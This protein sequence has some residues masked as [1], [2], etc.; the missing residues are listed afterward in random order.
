MSEALARTLASRGLGWAR[1]DPD[2]LADELLEKFPGQQ[3]HVDALV[4]T[5]ASDVL[6]ALI[7]APGSD[8]GAKLLQAHAD[9][10]VSEWGLDPGVAMWAVNAWLHAISGIAV[11][12]KEEGIGSL[13]GTT[14]PSDGDHGGTRV[15]GAVSRLRRLR[16][17]GTLTTRLA[18]TVA[19][20]ELGTSSITRGGR[21]PVPIPPQGEAGSLALSA[22]NPAE[23]TFSPPE[24]FSQGPDVPGV[25]D[26]TSP[27][28]PQTT[29]SAPV[30]P[31]ALA[32]GSTEAMPVLVRSDSALDVRAPEWL[33]RILTALS[34]ALAVAAKHRLTLLG[35]LATLAVVAIV[36]AT[37]PP[38]PE[39]A[40]RGLT[41]SPARSASGGSGVPTP[42]AGGVSSTAT[43]SGETSAALASPSP[44]EM[45]TVSVDELVAASWDRD[46]VE[47]IRV[48]QEYLG[49]RGG[50][51]AYASGKLYDAL[52]QYGIVLVGLQQPADAID[53]W[54]QAEALDAGRPEAPRRISTLSARLAGQ[55]A[56]EA[57]T[58]EVAVTATAISSPTPRVSVTASL[59]RGLGTPSTV[60]A[61]ET[62][63]EALEAV[64][65]P[66]SPAP[67]V[68]KSGP[69]GA[70]SRS[71]APTQTVRSTATAVVRLTVTP[72][73]T[74][75]PAPTSTNR[76]AP[77]EPPVPTATVPPP[78]TA[79]PAPTATK[80]PVPTVPPAPTATQPPAATPVP[81][82]TVVLQRIVLEQPAQDFV[83]T[84][85]ASVEFR[86]K[87]VPG[88]RKYR[89]QM[90]LADD[91]WQ[92]LRLERIT[93]QVSM[94]YS[95]DRS[96]AWMWR[97]A[98]IGDND[99]L[100]P[101]PEFLRRFS[102]K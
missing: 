6:S 74:A 63:V 89:V 14:G 26:A 41:A 7:G 86:W 2:A 1:Q 93:D 54:R 58:A 95:P 71:E 31:T 90:C 9:H 57:Q 17:P 60:R 47:A 61:T 20:P 25:S 102:A 34:T 70:V 62:P 37:T 23:P 32:N 91:C 15:T 50:S 59:V 85:G 73:P 46:W 24:G 81:A 51:D 92:D 84:V 87:Q 35:S 3:D 36:I 10:L 49:T 97:V 29:P 43:A 77:A 19:R 13:S 98:A 79:P 5:I 27:V 78:P 99:R 56:E 83:T 33:N 76:P 55:G 8:V 94:S 39:S 21:M 4:A 52:V 48:L 11:V 38:P 101:W 69:A 42:T 45:T 68:T 30:Q 18:L 66:V 53:T 88:A 80:V 75:S 16:R 22:S 12:D 72:K 64:E 100:G 96:G 40:S 44:K 82:A 65:V 28:P 67:T